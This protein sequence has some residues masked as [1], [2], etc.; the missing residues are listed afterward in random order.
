MEDLTGKKYGRWT[1]IK[2]VGFVNSNYRWLCRC[3]CGTEKIVSSNT[4]R[5]GK[6]VSCGCYA[7]ELASSKAKHSCCVN[8]QTKKI[9]NV[10]NSM[11]QRCVNPNN[12]AYK[13]YGKRGIKVCDEW[14]TSKNF[15]DW[16]YANGYKEGLTIDR[17]DTNGNYEPNN[18][19]WVDMLTQANNTNRNH[20]LTIGNE[21]H[22]IAEWA[23]LKGI[24]VASIYWRVKQGMS[25]EEAVTKPVRKGNYGRRICTE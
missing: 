24:N 18:C 16:A 4:F 13:H 3:D 22:T 6:S 2:Y 10:W 9:Y 15:V 11:I 14:R 1:V 25:F 19:R 17:I 8:Y 21:T 23:R 5:S 20:I 12:K 7:R